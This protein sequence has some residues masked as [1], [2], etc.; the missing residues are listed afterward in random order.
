VLIMG[1]TMPMEAW[2]AQVMH[3]DALNQHARATRGRDEFQV[4]VFDN[5]GIGLTE[6]K[7]LAS[8]T[9]TMAIDTLL[10]LGHL[11][12]TRRVHIVGI[13]LGGMVAQE[14]VLRAPPR[15]CA[16]L[17]LVNTHAGGLAAFAP[18]KGVRELICSLGERFFVGTSS[19]A[20][21]RHMFNMMWGKTVTEE[22]SVKYNDIVGRLKSEVQ[23]NEPMCFVGFMS[24]F[25]AVERHHVSCARLRLLGVSGLPVYICFGPNDSIVHQRN[26]PLMFTCITGRTP[27]LQPSEHKGAQVCQHRNVRL[28]RYDKVGHW[29]IEEWASHFNQ[30]LTTHIRSAQQR[31]RTHVPVA[32]PGLGIH[33]RT[34]VS[35]ILWL[36]AIRVAKRSQRMQRW[37][38]ALLGFSWCTVGTPGP[39]TSVRCANKGMFTRAMRAGP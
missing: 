4:C 16:S 5:R 39:W 7:T 32:L 1:L 19:D 12:W 10:L 36:L 33:W 35:I 14:L 2:R 17:T 26:S 18:W 22:D 29:L 24:Q 27:T 8:S 15:L 28:E 37:F 13:A 21:P 25:L 30:E 11:R 23:A 34:L 3:F 31:R 9:S 20:L 6:P 38:K